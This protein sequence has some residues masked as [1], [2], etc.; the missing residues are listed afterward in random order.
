MTLLS[1]QVSKPGVN[2]DFTDIIERKVLSLD[3]GC[4][5]LPF[6]FQLK[7]EEH[8]KSLIHVQVVHISHF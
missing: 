8:V 3:F 6:S 5:F 4:F 7:D 1:K 2:N